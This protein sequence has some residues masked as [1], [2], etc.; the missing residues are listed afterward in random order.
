[1]AYRKNNTETNIREKVKA[2][3]DK[4]VSIENT[5]KKYLRTTYPVDNNIKLVIYEFQTSD[6]PVVNIILCDK[7]VIKPRIVT[8]KDGKAFLSYPSYKNSDGDYINTAYC[9]DKE[10]IAVLN[11]IIKP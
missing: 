3:Y 7:F 11:E 4:A 10:L 9:F 6:I 8:G 2:I 1:M 5:E